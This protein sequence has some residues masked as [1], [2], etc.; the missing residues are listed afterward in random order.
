MK[1]HLPIEITEEG[2]KIHSN[3]TKK[4][5][6]YVSI[7]LFIVKCGLV[8]HLVFMSFLSYVSVLLLIKFAQQHKFQG[9]ITS[10]WKQDVNWTYI[11]LINF[12]FKFYVSIAVWKYKI[13][14]S[15]KVR[16]IIQRCHVKANI[17]E[18]EVSW[19]KSL[20]KENLHPSTYVLIIK[21]QYV[22]ALLQE[23]LQELF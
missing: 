12:H 10:L 15:E 14:F 23:L 9:S 18:L 3:L 11:C 16:I 4:Y 8:W 1:K 17:N 19:R 22:L 20:T 5:K 7:V 2:V 6:N 21:A 13:M